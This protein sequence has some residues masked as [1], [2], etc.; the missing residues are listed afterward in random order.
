MTHS[1][2]SLS[3]NRCKSLANLSLNKCPYD[4]LEVSKSATRSEIKEAFVSKTKKIHP[5][6]NISNPNLHEQ[7]VEL[8]EAYSILRDAEKR[9]T[10]DQLKATGF[11]SYQTTANASHNS[12][13]G[14]ERYT[15]TEE[16]YTYAFDEKEYTAIFRDFQ[17]TQ[18]KYKDERRSWNKYVIAAALAF[19]FAGGCVSVLRISVIKNMLER[20]A[21]K[22]NK[23]S[24]RSYQIAREKARV[25]GPEQ[26]L[27]LFAAAASS[28][29]KDKELAEIVTSVGPSLVQQISEDLC[30]TVLSIQS[31]IQLEP[32]VLFL[33]A[34]LITIHKSGNKMTLPQQQDGG[35]HHGRH[36]FKRVKSCQC[37]MLTASS[38]EYQM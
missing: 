3:H 22:I 4:V 13:Y 5:D 16:T 19:M 15:S 36:F 35:R 17:F 1:T 30:I 20:N 12:P 25:N 18:A 11:R 7:F 38:L 23:E 34:M 37:H 14:Q 10:Y 9:S 29:K 26:Q 6:R 21:E 28:K 31:R 27:K 8:N 2:R 32:L 33:S 24:H